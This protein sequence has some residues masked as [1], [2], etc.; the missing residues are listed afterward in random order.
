MWFQDQFLKPED[1][2]ARRD[3]A[4]AFADD[5]HGR[6]T[7]GIAAGHGAGLVAIVTFLNA[8]PGLPWWV[9]AI[10][11]VAAV[12]FLI[13]LLLVLYAMWMA[14]YFYEMRSQEFDLRNQ[15]NEFKEHFVQH[16]TAEE[17]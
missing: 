6:M 8:H 13:G 1:V 14:R 17:A 9:L 10:I 2:I 5:W 3:A 7:T 12:C 4:K 16:I 15:K 11:G